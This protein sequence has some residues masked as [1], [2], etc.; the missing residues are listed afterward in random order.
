MKTPERPCPDC[1]AAIERPHHGFNAACDGCAGRMLSR[2]P[3]YNESRALGRLT[4][5]YQAALR[6]VNLTH[7]H[8]QDA[9]ACDYMRVNRSTRP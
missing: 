5:G 8:V 2:S 3:V 6:S 4:P 7:K 1:Y 9:E